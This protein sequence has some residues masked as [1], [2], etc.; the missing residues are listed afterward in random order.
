M[1]ETA[2][3]CVYA[4]VIGLLLLALVAAASGF[5]LEKV[6]EVKRAD[7][8]IAVEKTQQQ[9]DYLAFLAA[10]TAMGK[11]V[12]A[13]WWIYAL[14]LFDVGLIGVLIVTWKRQR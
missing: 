1:S 9:R 10:M 11:Q 2:Q 8:V 7:G 6:A 12:G 3:G 4:I 14:A 5:L 13:P